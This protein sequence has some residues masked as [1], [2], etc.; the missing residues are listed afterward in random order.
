MKL[1]KV[2]KDNRVMIAF[3]IDKKL[4]TDFKNK[5]KELRKNGFKAN[6]QVI[7]NELIKEFLK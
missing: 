6:E 7:L 2:K 1:E 5:I 4:R 3:R